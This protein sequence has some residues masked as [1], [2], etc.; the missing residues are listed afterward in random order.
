MKVVRCTYDL[1][2]RKRLDDKYKQLQIAMAAKSL[3]LKDMRADNVGIK[4]DGTYVVI[5]WGMPMEEYDFKRSRFKN[6]KDI[7]QGLFQ[8]NF[9]KLDAFN[10][11]IKANRV[12]I[13]EQTS[14]ETIKR[15]L[16]SKD[17]HGDSNFKSSHCVDC[18]KTLNP[19]GGDS[20]TKFDKRFRSMLIDLRMLEALQGDFD[21]D[22][23]NV[24]ATVTDDPESNHDGTYDTDALLHPGTDAADPPADEVDKLLKILM[25]HVA[26]C[27]EM[28]GVCEWKDNRNVP[29]PD[30]LKNIS[31]I[32]VKVLKADEYSV[33]SFLGHG[34]FKIAFTI[35]DSSGHTYVAKLG[36]GDKY[37]NKDFTREVGREKSGS[38][39]SFSI[40]TVH[41]Y[42][43]EREY[44]CPSVNAAT[45]P[46]GIPRKGPDFLTG[47]EVVHY[48][49]LYIPLQIQ[50]KVELFEDLVRRTHT[51]AERKVL[52]LKYK[53]LQE[54]MLKNDVFIQDMRADNVG[55]R[56]DESLCI[57]DWGMFRTKSEYKGEVR[58]LY[59]EKN[60][61]FAKRIAAT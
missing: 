56:D 52:E 25:D 37:K 44:E 34:K 54:R 53:T 19:P 33:K 23:W 7:H 11:R 15:V 38:C 31:T 9:W 61:T 35:E 60:E 30:I 45:E 2:E 17:Q 12:W 10:N 6:G 16:N 5:D 51:M 47:E 1:A 8:R 21:A 55:I 58:S 13:L 41:Y 57:I 4:E 40:K 14:D 3:Y 28:E 48:E 39:E 46:I 36:I 26:D 22:V 49:Y 59:Q 29:R 50:P 32:L 24:D 18:L 42:R 27:H 43:C 20:E